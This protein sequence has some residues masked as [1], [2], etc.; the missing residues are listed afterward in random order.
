MPSGVF[1]LHTV[2][3]VFRLVEHQDD[4]LGEVGAIVLAAIGD[5]I[6]DPR[7]TAMRAVFG[8]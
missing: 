1:A 3:I 8:V 2:Q 5:G 7:N 4:V 6:S